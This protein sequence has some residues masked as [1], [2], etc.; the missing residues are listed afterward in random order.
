MLFFQ[1]EGTIGPERHF[2][3]VRLFAI[4]YLA[5]HLWSKPV[6]AMNMSV[7]ATTPAYYQILKSVLSAFDAVVLREAKS[8][9]T[10]QQLGLTNIYVC[11]DMA[12]LSHRTGPSNNM[13]ADS[14]PYFCVTGSAAIDHLDT[15]AYAKL[16]CSLSETLGL[17]AVVLFS[18]EKDRKLAEEVAIT[19]STAKRIVL[20][21]KELPG[22]CEIL[23]VL[24]GGKF[25]IGGRYHTSI[26]ALSQ[27]CPVILLP[28]NTHKSEG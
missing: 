8:F 24:A 26:S 7:Y 28:G 6:I 23:P 2:H 14:G 15:S 4:P 20:S 25:V 27:G 1:A 11:P 19:D 10:C 22:Y 12:F 13:L 21:T 5:K 18:R 9:A 3:G 16:V 17:T